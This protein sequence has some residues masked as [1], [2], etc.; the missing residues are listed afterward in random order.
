MWIRNFLEINMRSEGNWW[1][2]TWNKIGYDLIIIEVEKS[3][4]AGSLGLP[5]WLS[6]KESA[7]NAGDMGSTF[8]LGRFPW[9]R[10]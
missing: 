9:R 2:Y 7:C 10:K 6:G 8:G 1:E 3:V 4:Y 5:W